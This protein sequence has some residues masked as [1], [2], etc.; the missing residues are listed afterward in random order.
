MIYFSNKHTK[1]WSFHIA[2]QQQAINKLIPH[3][4]FIR[5]FFTLFI[6]SH[7]N[8]SNIKTNNRLFFC[9][10]NCFAS[11]SGNFLNSKL[12][13]GFPNFKL[14]EKLMGT[15]S[16][17]SSKLFFVSVQPFIYTTV[18]RQRIVLWVCMVFAIPLGFFSGRV[19]VSFWQ[20]QIV[21]FCWIGILNVL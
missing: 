9:G 2:L 15:Q 16:W 20:E 12:E 3:Y 6:F 10:W 11:H 4:F 14:Y 1:I 7:P 19:G 5:P 21:N 8:N 17:L 18:I 13:C